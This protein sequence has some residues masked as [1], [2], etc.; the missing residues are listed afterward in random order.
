[1]T[2]STCRGDDTTTGSPSGAALIVPLC[3]ASLIFELVR[4]TLG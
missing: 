3:F 4:V 2:W 1:M